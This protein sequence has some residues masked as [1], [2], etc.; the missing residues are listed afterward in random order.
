MAKIDMPDINAATTE[1]QIQQ[2]KDFLY[3]LVEQVGWEIDRVD[4]T[5]KK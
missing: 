5:N 3:K 4:T 2:I 1:G